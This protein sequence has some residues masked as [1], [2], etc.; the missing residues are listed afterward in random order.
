MTVSSLKDRKFLIRSSCTIIMLCNV[1]TKVEKN[2][3]LDVDFLV[4]LGLIIKNRTKCVKMAVRLT[5]VSAS[6]SVLC[7]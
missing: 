1:G 3:E 2:A 7:Q 6:V 4:Y 5:I